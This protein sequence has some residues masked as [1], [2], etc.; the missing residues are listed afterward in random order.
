MQTC[1]ARKTLQEMK[2]KHNMEFSRPHNVLEMQSAIK[3]FDFVNMW[4]F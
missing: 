2:R 1:N 3:H 4:F